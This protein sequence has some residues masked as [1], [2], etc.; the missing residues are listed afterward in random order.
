MTRRDF[1]AQMVR[2]MV[3]RFPPADVDEHFNALQDIPAEVFIAAV[4]HALKTRRDF[5]VPAELRADADAVAPPSPLD[6]DDPLRSVTIP[7]MAIE[8][9]GVGVIASVTREWKYYCERCH[10]GGWASMWCGELPKEPRIP[11]SQPGWCGRRGDHDGHEWVQHCMCWDSNPD[12]IRKR[13]SQ[14]K[15]S[16]PPQRV[17]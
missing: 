12:L 1:D 10:D 4:S 16:E 15:Y 13:A 5:P 2:L 7:A 6:E 9:P 17:A 11:W 8:V 14:R 3:L